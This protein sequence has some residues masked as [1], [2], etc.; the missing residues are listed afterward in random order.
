MQQKSVE[1]PV[2][3][4]SLIPDDSRGKL[5]E[6]DVVLDYTCAFLHGELVKRFLGDDH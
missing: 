1:I 3:E 6:V 2:V 5:P 4:C